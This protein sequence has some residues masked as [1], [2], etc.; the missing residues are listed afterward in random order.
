MS[1][2]PE[3]FL[4][5]AMNTRDLGGIRAAGGRTV[6]KQNSSDPANSQR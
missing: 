2:A 1:Y 5:G 4:A 3:C 6:A